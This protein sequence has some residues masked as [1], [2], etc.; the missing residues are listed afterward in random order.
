M[1]ST[2]FAV[3]AKAR[4]KFG[5]RLTEK[6][7][8]NLLNANSVAEIMSYLKSYTHY[9]EALR[10][11]NERDV[12]RGRLEMLLRQHIFYEFDSLCRYD[13]KMSIGFS[14]YVV[15]KTEIEQI[16]RFLTLLN[17]SSTEK[18]IYQYPAYFS[19]HTELDLQRLA[20]ARNYDEFLDVLSKTKYS[21][22]LSKYKP[23]ENNLLPISDIENELYTE[24]FSRLKKNI[25]KRTSG[26][27]R[28][29]IMDFFTTINDYNNFSRILRLKKY[30]NLSPEQI[31]RNLLS[32]F[33]S[34]SEKIIDKMCRAES[35]GEVFSIMQET[36]TGKMIEQIGYVYASD[37][38]PRVKYKLARRNMFFSNNPSVVMIS[39][40]FLAETELMNIISLIEGIR[41][42]LDN[43]K[44]QSLLIV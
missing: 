7:Y 44:I 4:A 41:Y 9:S 38:S 20:L 40:M 39:Y 2:S 5:K 11:V 27:E 3:L 16:M 35:S 30:Y 37:I 6:D 42:N 26:T 21:Q 33:S 23:D 22:I 32:P 8:N 17:T 25:I 13:S 12:H 36:H 18:F 1:S 29:E 43:K 31:K 15:E 10:D 14:A 24:I 34:I 19:K 28:K